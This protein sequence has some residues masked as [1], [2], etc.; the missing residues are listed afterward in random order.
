MC[1]NAQNNTEDY[2]A[3]NVTSAEDEK[4][5][6]GSILLFPLLKL[7]IFL[8]MALFQL[9]LDVSEFQERDLCKSRPTCY[10]A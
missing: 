4:S 5:W 8:G 2:L 1:Y 7:G 6:A 9:G 10:S 3:P